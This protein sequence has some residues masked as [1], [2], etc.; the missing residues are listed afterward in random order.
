MLGC[1]SPDFDLSGG[2][3]Q[4]ANALSTGNGG[5]MSFGGPGGV[6]G[7]GGTGPDHCKNGVPDANETGNDCG[8]PDCKKCPVGE[9]CRS[10]SDCV[11][12][13]CTQNICRNAACSDE[14]LNG[15]ETDIDCGGGTCP[16][17]GS[18]KACL[19]GADCASLNCGDDA[20]CEAA[21]CSDRIRNGTETD[22]DCGGSCPGCEVGDHCLLTTDCQP[23]PDART[24]SINC[25]P[26]TETCVLLCGTGTADC[27][28]SA[29]DG[30]EV[31]LN[32]DIEHCGQCDSP[33]ELDNA[34]AQ[35]QGGEC[36]IV[37]CMD[38][39]RNCNQH[40]DDGCETDIE[41]DP[42]HCG[43]C[44][45]RCSDHNGTAQ[46]ARGR[47]SIECDE[48]YD[49]CNAELADGCEANLTRSVD[50]CQECANAC[51]A[52]VA[53]P[54]PFCNGAADGC[55]ETECAVGLGDCDGDG[56]CTDD[57]TSIDDCGRCGNTCHVPNGK[58]ACNQGACAVETC[59]SGK[60][61]IWED[62][63]E[64]VINGCERNLYRDPRSCGACDN[65]C[66]EILDAGLNVT[67]V[68][69]GAGACV[70]TSCEAGFANC[71]GE[72]DNGCEVD[73]TTD[74]V[75][76]GGCSDQGGI[77]CT[78]EYA[79]G[80]GACEGSTCGF[81]GC[82]ANWADC[83]QNAGAGSSRDGCET[84]IAFNDE[85]CGACGVKCQINAGTSENTCGGANGD[86]CQ[87]VCA[88]DYDS[89]DDN[90]AN[91]C[92]ASLLDSDEHC[93]GCNNE[94]QDINSQNRCSNGVCDPDCD[95]NFAN[96]DGDPDD[97]CEQSTITTGHCGGCGKACSG[98]N[99][100]TATCSAAGQCS[101]S[102]PGSFKNCNAEN[103][104]RDGCETDTATDPDHCGAC[105]ASCGS[106]NV[107]TRTCSGGTCTP[108]CNPGFCR[109]SDPQNGC[110]LPL[111]TMDNCS[112]CGDSCSAPQP[113]CASDGGFHC[114]FLDIEV[115]NS[116]TSA[117]SS[118]WDGTTNTVLTVNHAL[119][120]SAGEYRAV[121]IG[122][123]AR[124]EPYEVRYDGAP[125]EPV[126]TEGI[127]ESWAGIYLVLD[128]QL[129]APGNKQVRVQ[130]TEGA[131]WGFAGVEVTELTG[132]DQNAPI[133]TTD[134]AATESDCG[135][136]G[137]RSVGVTFSGEAGSFV[138]A[139]L[140]AR[141]AS[142]ATFMDPVDFLET[143]NRGVTNPQTFRAVAG[144][145]GPRSTGAIASWQMSGCWE[146][147]GVAVGIKRAES[148]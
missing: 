127:V 66:N 131:G 128:S 111:G 69:C 45:E 74:P 112:A 67:A 114:D 86:T 92:E 22:I 29:S 6:A 8:G 33:C 73:T 11:N 62:C 25:D 120:S 23:P 103:A 89:C 28:R 79:N 148:L 101:V 13:E 4:D 61:A 32:T 48:G 53:G 9:P 38:G 31:T 68:A 104:A 40:T 24:E 136:G 118:G 116:G 78:Q 97:G 77:D 75:R 21:S 44:Y 59:D 96:C 115:V 126:V 129:A 12:G 108:T 37:A 142:G 147:A 130:L 135:T 39:F 82:N 70:I 132:V 139:V 14:I 20:I 76:C 98:A 42:S 140:G 85:H 83:N 109:S 15:S 49:D 27:N 55:G 87:P 100:G 60:A 43:T 10:A 84:S 91:G 99:G 7:E 35:C 56:E 2:N 51:E 3:A 47:C 18:G 5:T 26:D 88:I 36:L 102:C 81:Q 57:L 105:G 95:D 64:L 52:S 138:Y 117:A 137:L 133:H 110:T 58:P 134:S 93:G 17:C 46:C 121:V 144:H 71:D 34:E 41:S 72:F 80:S 145:I 143:M 119:E 63:D 124:A 94:C 125:L 122:V 107:A 106:T 90:P 1:D 54:T 123:A 30:C 16:A 65:D 146:S 19:E 50:H 141:N 113:F